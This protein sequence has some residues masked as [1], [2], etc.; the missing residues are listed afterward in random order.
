MADDRLSEIQARVRDADFVLVGLGEEFAYDWNALLQDA[1]YREIEEETGGAQ[2]YVWITPF[3]QKMILRQRRRDRWTCAY[4]NLESMI[5]GKNYFVVSL[6]MDDYI[7]D[8]ALDR[9]K[10]VTPCGGFRKMQCDRNCSHMLTELPEESY[11]A[12]LQYYRKE[13]PLYAL[14]EPVCE[15]CGAGLRFNQLG[16][17]R[18]AEEGY[19]ENWSKYTKW[20]QGTVNRS[21]CVLELG[22]GM[23][24]PTVIRF[25]FEKIVLYNQKAILYRI[26]SALWQ[27]GGE[28]GDRGCSVR[29][30]PIDWLGWYD[31]GQA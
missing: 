9:E 18:Y 19:L 21:L 20:L 24:Y 30:D 4:Q 15:K 5:A 28:L 23:E 27:I 17:T 8:T 3:L 31:A 25:P 13:L 2:E 16:V 7:Y 1:R 29:E 26:H 12:V 14:R 22:V 10:I 6:C 11:E